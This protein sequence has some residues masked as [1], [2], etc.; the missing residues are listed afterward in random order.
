MYELPVVFRHVDMPGGHHLRSGGHLRGHCHVFMVGDMSRRTNMHRH[1]DLLQL[2]VSRRAD[3]S[4]GNNLRGE[5]H[6]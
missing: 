2:H 1:S 6:L 4:G 5:Y 3:M